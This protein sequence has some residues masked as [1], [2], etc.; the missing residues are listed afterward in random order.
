MVGRGRTEPVA[1][2]A[3]TKDVLSAFAKLDKPA[4]YAVQSAIADFASGSHGE[5]RLEKVPGSLDDRIRLLQVDDAWHGAVLVPDS[6]DTYCLLTILPRD[7]AAGY[8]TSHRVGV[9]QVTGMLEVRRP[10]RTVPG[11]SLTSA[12]PTWPGWAST[13][14]SGS[15][16]GS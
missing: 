13:G 5:A 16:C 2:L 1:R 8:A 9:N 11:C 15:W 14:T 10:A 12:T 3:I 4:Q 7:E 6:G